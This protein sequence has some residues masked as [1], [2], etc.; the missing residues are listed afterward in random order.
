[1]NSLLDMPDIWRHLV[2][3][4]VVLEDDSRQGIYI[5][6]RDALLVYNAKRFCRALK[7]PWTAATAKLE[8]YIH[9]QHDTMN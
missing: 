4:V 5:D 8:T 2:S 1:M 6:V 9:D 7:I 3:M